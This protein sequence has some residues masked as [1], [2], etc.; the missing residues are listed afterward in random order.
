[1]AKEEA[2]PI[3]VDPDFAKIIRDIQIKRIK[4]GRDNSMRPGTQITKAMI[5]HK[6]FQKI[7]DDI[8]GAE[9]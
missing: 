5:R 8:L 7:I 6:D 1:M 2:K 3:R 9:K 4:L